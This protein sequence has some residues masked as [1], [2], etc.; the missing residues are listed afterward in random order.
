MT[1]TSENQ[2]VILTHKWQGIAAS[3]IGATSIIINLLLV[4]LATSGTEPPT[5][6]IASLSMLSSEMLCANL[7]GIALGLLVSKIARRENS[8]R[9]L[10]LP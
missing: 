10:V 8:T 2:A 1:I 9:Y 3:V 7:I 5:R 4:G 6:M